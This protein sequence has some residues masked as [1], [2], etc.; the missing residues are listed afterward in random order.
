M[1]S[2]LQPKTRG[3]P[4]PNREGVLEAKYTTEVTVAFDP[5]VNLFYLID[6]TGSTLEKLDRE[7]MRERDEK[8]WSRFME[9]YGEAIGRDPAVSARAARDTNRLHLVQRLRNILTRS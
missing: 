9:A 6:S 3:K 1:A 4:R 5:A 2:K 8:V 7:Q